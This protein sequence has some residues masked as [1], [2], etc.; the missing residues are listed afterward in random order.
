[1]TIV[2][3]N[4]PKIG[5]GEAQKKY[6]PYTYSSTAKKAANSSAYLKKLFC[7]SKVSFCLSLPTLKSR[8]FSTP[9][10]LKCIVSI[11]KKINETLPHKHKNRITNK[12]S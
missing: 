2:S 6:E 10:L 12:S 9:P 11:Y 8:L 1:M 4:S 5:V 3:S 7:C